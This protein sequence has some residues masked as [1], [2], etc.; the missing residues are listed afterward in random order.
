MFG[1]EYYKERAEIFAALASAASNEPMAR[2][3]AWMAAECLAKAQ[4]DEASLDDV[5]SIILI[6][7]ALAGR[8]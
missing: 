6:P 1:P 4:G 7:R 5:P 2:L 3:Y 8:S